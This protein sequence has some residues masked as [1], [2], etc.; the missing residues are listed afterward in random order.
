M[1]YENDN[2]DE[3]E[4]IHD[5]E[6]E[7][8]RHD[9]FGTENEDRSFIECVKQLHEC[10][11]VLF[12]SIFKMEVHRQSNGETSLVSKEPSA[13]A[14]DEVETVS[15]SMKEISAMDHQQ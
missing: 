14:H 13:K 3:S 1:N 7:V 11:N 4:S 15:S 9:K 8:D 2:R 12:E 5:L 6:D 10:G